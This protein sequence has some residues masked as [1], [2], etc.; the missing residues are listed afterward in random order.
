MQSSKQV[1]LERLRIDK[2]L[3][4]ARFYKTR[5]IA[6]EEIH[7]GRVRVNEAECKPAREVKVGD[8]IHLRQGHTPRTVVVQALSARR[9]PA[10]EAQLLYQETD[11]SIR[12]RTAL[13]EQRY[14]APEPAHTITQGRPTKRDRRQLQQAREHSRDAWG[15][16]WS[17]SV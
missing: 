11:E 7:K 13:Q 17:A 4:A 3:W 14:F 5:A 1:P 12:L 15:K 8:T 9:G 16:R 6:V 2:W 10:P